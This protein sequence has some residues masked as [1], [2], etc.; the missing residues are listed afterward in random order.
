LGSIAGTR[1]HV[2]GLIG[3]L[4]EDGADEGVLLLVSEGRVRAATLV[5]T[6][7]GATEYLEQLK[8]WSASGGRAGERIDKQL[9]HKLDIRNVFIRRVAPLADHAD[10][11]LAELALDEQHPYHF[12]HAQDHVPGMMLIEAGRQLAMAIAHV[13]Y[14]V[15]TEAVFVLN[16]VSIAFSRFAELKTPVYVHAQVRDKSYRRD[17]LVAMSSGGEFLQNGVV[18]GTMSGRWTMFDQAV[19][20]RMRRRGRS[21]RAAAPAP[22]SP[23]VE[24]STS[25]A[26]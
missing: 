20:D 6:R 22:E 21:E 18:L 9:V 23:L 15:S 1:A 3:V 12:E 24:T 8:V 5:E 11:H 16:E 19:I 17:Q 13:Y 26:G 25:R 14:G 10:E 4:G 2:A 7:M